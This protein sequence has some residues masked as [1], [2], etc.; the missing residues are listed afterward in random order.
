MKLF[1]S[2]AIFF[3]TCFQV[4]AQ[5][6]HFVY[7]QSDN[8]QPFYVRLKEKLYSSSASGYV[9]LPKLS[10]GEQVLSFGFPNNEFAQQSISINIAGKDLGF[11]LKNFPGKGWG[12]FNI[13]TMDVVMATGSS[14]SSTASN[15]T[16]TRTDAFSS[17]LADVVNTPSIKEVE[18]PQAKQ[19]PKAEV[20]VS[21]AP[22]AKVEE[23]KVAEPVVVQPTA[24][25]TPATGTMSV[26]TK[27]NSSRSATALAMQYFVSDEFGTDTVDI[28]IAVPTE[29]V[30]AVPP[31]TTA[32][33]QDPQTS[34]PAIAE[35]KTQPTE[36]RPGDPKF[37]NIDLP[38][39]NTATKTKEVE[40]AKGEDNAPKPVTEAKDA[41]KLEMINSDCKKVADEDDFLK[42]RK[43]MTSQKSDEAMVESAKKLF[44][45]KCYSTQQVKNLSVLFLKDETRYKFYDA[46][47]PFVYD[48]KEFKQLESTLTDEYYIS[49]F[50]SMIR[51]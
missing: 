42:T 30:A 36:T 39:P 29:V 1:L 49:R 47:Y 19:E 2:I 31:P 38:N 28:E 20:P 32:A 10:A 24:D 9:I 45:Q 41:Q 4:Q 51:N 11:L 8:K 37:I 25:P 15:Q 18:K 21:P 35:V 3:V 34:I 33:V 43:K 23:V 12:L 5:H 7:V 27:T 16:E 40:T 46:V 48:S 13:Q 14:K 6:N 17:T 44:K 26:I 22:V 50:R